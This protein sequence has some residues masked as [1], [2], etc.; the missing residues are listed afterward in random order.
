MD[1]PR[2]G[3]QDA[4]RGSSDARHRQ[5]PQTLRQPRRAAGSGTRTEADAPADQPG[6]VP[7][8][9]S[10]APRQSVEWYQEEEPDERPTT[11]RGGAARGTLAG[12]WLRGLTGSLAFGLLLVTL[13][14][15]GVQ[16]WSTR[17]GEAG[18]GTSMIVTHAVG[19][20]LALGL[21]SFADRHRDRQGAAALL[22]VFLAVF[23]ALW[24]WWWL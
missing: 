12:T 21:Q 24:Y 1:M 19:V 20:V 18:P 9:S 22:G 14:L 15:I 11:R 5:P 6:T 23:G 17:Q 2:R 4:A 16:I 8:R 7:F 3:P 10:R 13:G